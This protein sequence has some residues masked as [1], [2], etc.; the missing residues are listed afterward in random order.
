MRIMPIGL[1]RNAAI[2]EFGQLHLTTEEMAANDAW[3]DAIPENVY[4]PCPCGCGMKF[5]FAMKEGLEPHEKRFIENFIT[6]LK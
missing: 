1:S 5:R 2:D 3:I 4:D 6:S